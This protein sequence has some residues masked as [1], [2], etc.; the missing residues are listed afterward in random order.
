MG[1]VYLV[2]AGPGDPSLLTLRAARLLRRADVI[3]HDALISAEVLAMIPATAERIDV[4]KRC[5]GRNTPQSAI[6]Q[7]LV[8]TAQRA[9]VVV[10][11]KGGDP[12]VFGRGGEEALALQEAGIRFEVVPGVTAA[13]GATAYAGIPLTHRGISSAVT[14]VTGH[15]CTPAGEERV[16]WDRLALSRETLVIYMGVGSLPQV[17]ERLIRSGR[18]PLTPAAVIHWGTYARQRV[19]EG[20]LFRIAESVQEAGIGAPSLV[21]I[22]EVANLRRQIAWFERRPL[23]GRRVLVPR[24]R[25]QRSRL[26]ASLAARGADVVEFP[27]MTVQL[28]SRPE[29]LRR[30]LRAIETFNWVVFTAPTA[31]QRFWA[32]AGEQGLDAR[33][34]AGVRFASF[35]TATGAALQR[36]G[37]RPDVAGSTFVP[38]AVIG[39]L[40]GVAKLEGSRVLFPRDGETPSVLVTRLSEAGAEVHEVE[41]YREVVQADGAETMEEQLASGKIDVVA[42]AS[43]STVRRFVEA[44]GPNAGL[45]AVAVIGSETADTALSL[46]LPVHIQPAEPTL[47]GFIRGIHEHLRTIPTQQG[48]HSGTAFGRARVASQR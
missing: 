2:G 34:F 10:R 9:R 36:Y 13:L 18:S 26:A 24:S 42:F 16:D 14:L 12:F 4:G 5:G 30:A 38:A 19:V 20:P 44:A 32:E 1:R 43:S 3:V 27:R 48:A 23:F 22:G 35:G 39:V 15:E 7:L 21:V 28:P 45:A 17:A 46:G 33:A 47:H 8:E 37:I 41:V 31:V 11:L 6:N 40:S 25:S 29:P